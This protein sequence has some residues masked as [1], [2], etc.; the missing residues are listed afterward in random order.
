MLKE[1]PKIKVEEMWQMRNDFVAQYR[2]L[3]EVRAKIMKIG[4]I[5]EECIDGIEFHFIDSDESFCLD[6]NDFMNKFEKIY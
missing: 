2:G 5:T 4:N 3:N 1:L 6:R